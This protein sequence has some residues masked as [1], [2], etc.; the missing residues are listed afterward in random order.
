MDGLVTIRSSRSQSV[1]CR[2]FDT[3][4]DA[5]TQAHYL[6]IAV[7]SAF[8]LWLDLVSVFLVGFVIFGCLF[9]DESNTFAG[10]VGLA[11]TQVCTYSVILTIVSCF[12]K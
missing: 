5:H 11:I 9:A 1:V 12:Q 2:R 6:G 3:Y 8:G 10:S 4:Q 7:A